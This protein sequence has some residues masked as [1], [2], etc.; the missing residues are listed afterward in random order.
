MAG[1]SPKPKPRGKETRKP[2]RPEQ[3]HEATVEE[4]ER[5]GMGVASKE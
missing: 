4:F 5:E 1:R 3:N 2:P